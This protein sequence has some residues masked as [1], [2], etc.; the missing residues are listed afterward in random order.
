MM[1]PVAMTVA[2]SDSGGGA[3]IQA[4]LKTFAMLGVFGTSALTALTAQN[5]Q[6]VQGIHDV[7]PE[8]V[9]SQI[10]SIV[11][12]IG[13]D[14]MKT[15]MLSNAAIIEMVAAKITEYRIEKVVVDP[16]MVATSGDMLLQPEARETLRTRLLPLAYLVTPNLAEA[17][18]LSGQKIKTLEEMKA[19]ARQIHRSG[20]Q[21][22]LIKGGH[23]PE[24]AV[25]LLYDGKEFRTFERPHI[26]TPHTHGTGCI[27]SAAIAAELAKGA[28]VE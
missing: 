4:D 17:E 14:A 19:A 12:D 1:L 25:D 15:G 26:D 6:G 18:V 9:G 22:V 28:G 10:D 20:A 2:G 13:V 3:G 24:K 23:F 8:F 7:P 21:R 27:L 11:T 16:V 5:T